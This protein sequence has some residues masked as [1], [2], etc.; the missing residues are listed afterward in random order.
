MKQV[1]ISNTELFALVDDEDFER[2]SQ[3]K[4][5]LRS[6]YPWRT[7]YHV[8][9]KKRVYRAI[10]LH[11]FVLGL[12]PN[13]P[14]VDHKDKNKLN[15][16][17]HNLRICTQSQNLGNTGLF[18]NNTSG[19]KGVSF[20]RRYNKWTAHINKNGKKFFIGYFKCPI[21]AAKAYD[22]EASVHF[23]EFAHL[24]FPEDHAQPGSQHPESGHTQAA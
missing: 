16:Q 2:V 9:N 10:S 13:R 19:Y 15:C 20:Y 18:R 12:P 22:H 3:F 8:V 4:W 21:A 5:H 7:I 24:N 14:Y 17:K 1:P 23:G 6:G 11:R